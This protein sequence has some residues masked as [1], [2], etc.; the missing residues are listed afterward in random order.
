MR[1]LSD[2]QQE[3]FEKLRRLKVGALFMGCGTGKTQT[4][5]SLINSIPG[6]DLVL[7]VAP[8]RTIENASKEIELRCSEYEFDFYGVESIG[9]SDRVYVEVL[10]KIDAAK[11]AA[12][13]VDESIKIKNLRAK[14]TQ[15]LLHMG[16]RC[17]YK[18]ILNGTP[19]TKN[20]L[21][22][23]AQMLFL[24]PK[25]L[26]KNFFKFRDDYCV[27]STE[28]RYGKPVRTYITGYANVEHLLSIIEPYVYE[29]SLDLPLAK[30]YRTLTWHMTETERFG[31]ENLKCELIAAAEDDFEILGAMQKLHHFYTLASEKV[32]LITPYVDD[33]TIIYCRFIAARDYLQEMFPQALVMTY[34]KGSFGLNLQKYRRIIYFDKTFDYAFRE[35]SEARI[36]R[37]GQQESCE[38]FDLT[39]ADIGLEELFDKCIAKKLTLVNAFKLSGMKLEDL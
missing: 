7:W 17:E 5:V 8:L 28:H 34:G 30:K 10:D 9:Q 21:D 31:Y 35:Q 22:I 11:C 3:A 13:V 20:I 25:I 14:R 26:D 16:E 19:I 39:G 15:R 38:Y 18:L 1:L 4:A 32:P 37:M 33:R 36:Y 23:Y 24:S 2:N 12:I 6:L 27:Y 29:C